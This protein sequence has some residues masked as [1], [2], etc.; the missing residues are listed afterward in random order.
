MKISVFGMGYVGAVSGACLA[1]MGHEVVGVD[2]NRGKIDLI[3]AGASPVVEEGLTEL[4]AQAHR[5]GRISATD[6][7]I[8]AVHRTEISLISVGTPTGPDGGQALD[9]LDSVVASIGEGVRRKSAPHGVV[10]RSTVMPRTTEERIAPNLEQSSGRHLGKGL[11]LSFNPEFLREG[12]AI[13]DFFQPPFIVIGGVREA[14][15]TLTTALYAGIDAPVFATTARIAESLKYACNAYHAVKI[16]FANELG[17]VMKSMGIDA[18]ETMRLFCEERQ[19]N[20]SSAYLRP[21]FAF[22]GSCLPKELRAIESMAKAAR[23]ELPMLANVLASNDRHV[24]R[25]FQMIQRRGRRKVALFGLAFKPG[26]DDLRESPLVALAERLIGKGYEL[27]IFDQ[28]VD[29]ARLTGTNL[30]YIKR[31]IPHLGRLVTKSVEEALAGAS[32]VVIGHAPSDAV[33]AIAAAAA[34]RSIVDLQG[35]AALQNLPNVDYE[36][37]CW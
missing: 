11:E 28:S 16:A 1:S 2:V 17:V 36:G 18:R 35:V 24:D 5:A 27:A 22:G 34:G 32:T 29:L 10:L 6:D 23:L 8:E 3:N 12:A 31:E 37:I 21:G 14:G 26:T 19:L 9:A 20:I 30:E 33:D 7:P 25:A 15:C 13:R 4:I